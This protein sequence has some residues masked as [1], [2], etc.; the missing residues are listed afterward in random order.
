MTESKVRTRADI[1]EK[2]KWNAPSVFPTPQ[3]WDAE[4]AQLQKDIARL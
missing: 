2:Y 3:D 1:P 4:A